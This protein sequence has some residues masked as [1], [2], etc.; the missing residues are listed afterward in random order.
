MNVDE[1]AA[2]GSSGRGNAK[3]AAKREEVRQRGTATTTEKGVR[4]EG[5]LRGRRARKNPD[6]RN[7]FAAGWRA[8][9][10]EGCATARPPHSSELIFVRTLILRRDRAVVLT[11][12]FTCYVQYS[13]V[14]WRVNAPRAVYTDDIIFN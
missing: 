7:A 12:H 6:F 4:D 5:R 9:S 14:K 1:G 13:G 3:R 10:S 2:R 11:V 8:R